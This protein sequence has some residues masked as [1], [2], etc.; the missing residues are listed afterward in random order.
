MRFRKLAVLVVAAVAVTGLTSCTTKVGA[1]AVVDGHRISDSDV[2]H[3]LTAQSVPFSVSSQS[4]SAQ[5]IV[6]RSYVLQSLILGTVFGQALAE[7]KGGTPTEAELAATEQSLA[8]GATPEQQAEQYTKYG[9][10]SPFAAVDIRNSTLEGI[11]AQRVGVQTEA[12]LF[13]EITKLKIAI[14]VSSRYGSWDAATF[15]L[16]SGPGAGAPSFVTLPGQSVA[17]APPAG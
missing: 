14:S 5:T 2:N 8:Q 12:A 1:A 13:A 17:A 9:F 7:T 11:L 6:P 15:S 4:G 3:Y 10:T 16:S